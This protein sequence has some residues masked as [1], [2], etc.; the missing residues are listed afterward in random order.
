MP[1]PT[2]EEAVEHANWIKQKKQWCPLK[3]GNC[4]RNCECLRIGDPIQNK[5]KD[6]IPGEYYCNCYMLQGPVEY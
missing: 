5:D 6:W 3:R 2:R 1:F 4:E